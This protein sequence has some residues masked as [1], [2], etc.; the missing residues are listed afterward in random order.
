MNDHARRRICYSKELKLT[1]TH[2]LKFLN[3]GQM[4]EIDGGV[5]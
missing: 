3:K 2:F 1:L 4:S 5:G